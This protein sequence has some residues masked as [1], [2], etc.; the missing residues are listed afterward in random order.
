MNLINEGL[1]QTGVITSEIQ[2]EIEG[3]H[4]KITMRTIKPRNKKPLE[5]EAFFTLNGLNALIGS[6]QA[7]ELWMEEH[8]N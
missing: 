5:Q 4:I 3:K 6:L 8:D 2:S 1:P 7:Q